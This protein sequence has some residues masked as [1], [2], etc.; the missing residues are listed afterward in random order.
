MNDL[1]LEYRE[2]VTRSQTPYPT[3]IKSKFFPNS[4]GYGKLPWRL[5]PIGV[6]FISTKLGHY[7]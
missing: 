4:W 3:T 7:E 2:V 6:M 1:Y 5:Y